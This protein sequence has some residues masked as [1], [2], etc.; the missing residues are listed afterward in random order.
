MG[1]PHENADPAWLDHR[2]VL[3]APE[4]SDKH[5]I[6]RPL[7]KIGCCPFASVLMKVQRGKIVLPDLMTFLLAAV[8]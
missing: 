1:D 3:K 6:F 4:D 7:D 8:I 5:F 2:G